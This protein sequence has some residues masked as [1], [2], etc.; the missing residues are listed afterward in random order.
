MHLT[1]SLSLESNDSR[2]PIDLP[3]SHWGSQEFTP[4]PPYPDSQSPYVTSPPFLN[5][6][7]TTETSTSVT[8]PRLLVASETFGPPPSFT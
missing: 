7:K 5:R 2:L 4:F 6:A 3:K 1:S 8:G